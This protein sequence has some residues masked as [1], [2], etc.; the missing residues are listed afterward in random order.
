MSEALV[1]KSIPF[2]RPII[3]DE[4]KQA[5]ADVLEGP[6]LV[7]GPKATESKKSK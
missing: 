6:I 2:G 1:K 5:V 4:E 7:H 3:G